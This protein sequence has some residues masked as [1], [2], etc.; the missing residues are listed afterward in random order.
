MEV[1]VEEIS[2]L[3]KK[4]VVTLPAD[5]VQ[6]KLNQAYEKLKKDTKIKGFRRG[7]VPHTVIV[8]SY[9]PQVEAEVGEKLVQDTYFDAIEKQGLDPIVHPEIS[10]VKYNDDGSFTYEAHV[11]TKPQFEL[12][13]Y[14]G[15]EVDMPAVTVTED[16]VEAELKALQKDMAV[17]RGVEDR[18]IAEGD[19]V[20]VD[21]QG[22]HKGNPM[23]QVKNEDYS[24]DVGSGRMGREFEE[25]LIGMK[26]EEEGS[27]TV[28]F[29]GE[30]SQSSAGRQGNRVQNQGQ[31]CQGAGAGRVQ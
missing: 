18:P 24:V 4:V 26:K 1:R 11:D 30:T 5:D 7:K 10:S 3:T 19:V 6:P 16:E 2:T 20:V 9:K 21:F 17:L 27:H 29:P 23:K 14:K 8:K 15:I 12:A 13:D 28:T 25:K 22:Y 31:G